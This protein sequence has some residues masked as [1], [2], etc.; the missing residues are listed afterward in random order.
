MSVT[1]KEQLIS[2]VLKRVLAR[3]TLVVVLAAA[4]RAG[5]APVDDYTRVRRL[6]D[7]GATEAALA[8]VE[9]LQ[10]KAP[11]APGWAAWESLRCELL[12]RLGRH[13]DLLAR[14][15]TIPVESD[16]SL[17]TCLVEGA[18]SAIAQN[19]PM[20]ARALAA[21]LL[22]QRNATPAQ[23]QTARV[24]VIES[25]IAERRGEDAFRSM[26]R[27]QQDYQPL[28][29]PIAERFAE[30]L[31]DLGQ[32]RDALNWLDRSNDVTG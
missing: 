7:A 26:L 15:S 1:R 18:R 12:A 13:V 20:A 5:A 6:A 16:A 8:S 22:W 14:A 17:A 21:R 9:T 19:D 4:I 24:S 2:G 23:A 11:R 30:A 31:L 29:R 10:P 28:E 27:Y 3:T 32:D 25:Y